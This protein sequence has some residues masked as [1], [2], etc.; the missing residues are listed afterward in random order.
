MPLDREVVGSNS[1]GCW[2]FSLLHPIDRASLIR[3]FKDMQRYWFFHKYSNYCSLGW[4][5]LNYPQTEQ[6][7]FRII[8]GVS[9][10]SKNQS[11]GRPFQWANPKS[12]LRVP[13]HHLRWPWLHPSLSVSFFRRTE[14]LRR[15]R[16]GCNGPG[17]TGRSPGSWRPWLESKK[18]DQFP[19]SWKPC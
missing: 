8:E 1:A 17:R 9:I 7:K 14:H 18:M 19:S 5:K 3:Y 10:I 16:P 12:P 13:A 15:S 4:S 2:A 6:R 11:T